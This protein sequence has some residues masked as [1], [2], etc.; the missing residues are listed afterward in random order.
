MDSALVARERRIAEQ[1]A[2]IG[3][4]FAQPGRR[5]SRGE[6]RPDGKRLSPLHVENASVL[7]DRNPFGIG[8]VVTQAQRD[9][10]SG[11]AHALGD[12][13]DM[14]EA[15][16]RIAHADG[17]MEPDTALHAKPPRQFDWGQGRD[18]ENRRSRSFPTSG[19]RGESRANGRGEGV[20]HPPAARAQVEAGRTTSRVGPAQRHPPARRP[21]P[22]TLEL[23][24]DCS[25]AP[26]KVWSLRR[27]CLIFM[28]PCINFKYA[29]PGLSA[30]EQATGR[31]LGAHPFRFRG[32]PA[33]YLHCPGKQP[34]ARRRAGPHVASCSEH[35]HKESRGIAGDEAP[36]PRKQRRYAH[37]AGSGDAATR[38][39]RA[40]A[41][42]ASLLGPSG[43][44]AG[45][46]GAGAPLRQHNGDH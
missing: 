29:K 33:F 30:S 45:R 22:T 9:E 3:A 14:G 16:N 42:G 36:L 25:P 26:P 5:P 27:T 1:G 4:V 13:D 19:P 18:P 44:C 34:Y 8:N 6:K 20:R 31:V 12:V 15:P 17:A 41:D 23:G 46:E 38:A 35:A 37:A 24:R 11:L 21:S 7:G 10:W 40:A 43:I 32:P 28:W 39:R 2:W